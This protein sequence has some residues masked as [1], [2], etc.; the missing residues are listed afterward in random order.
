MSDDKEFL[1]AVAK[2]GRDFIEKN[3]QL[4]DWIESARAGARDPKEVVKEVWRV[5]AQNKTF[6]DGV[7]R[8]LFEAFQVDSESTDLA[9][10]P[11]REKL[12]TRWGFSEEDLIFQPFPDRPDYHMLHPLLMGM[13]VEL[14][15]FDGDVPELRTGELPE[16]G[17]P[18]V[19]VKTTARDPIV[20]G[21]ML[22]QASNE[23]LLELGAAREERQQKLEKM[24]GAM[25]EDGSGTTALIR[26]ET[27]RGVAV[28]GYRPGHKAAIRE[29]EAPS[30]IEVARMPLAE[31]QELAHKA[32]TSTQ[33]RRSAV[34][35]I[36]GLVLERLQGAGFSSLRMGG[37]KE[38]EYA[39]VVS[40]TEWVISID[41][42]QAERNPK[43]NF[44]DTAAGALT[45]KLQRGL[46][47]RASRY[48]RLHLVVAPVN[49][50]SER[51]VGWRATV[52]S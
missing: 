45:V 29:V 42:G 31:R 17:S 44:I 47:G 49:E 25:P 26:Q 52:Y 24:I 2:F 21:A 14:L 34:P 32:L 50:I 15:Q 40:E 8:A 9:H 43:F 12:L 20:V 41:G 19:P 5:A 22:R 28:A 27:E 33:G 36:A 7:E 48:T 46:A 10:F 38:A 39:Y 16:G 51:R 35:I 37:V 6:K 30:A 18:A 1:D 4:E 11:E 13:I 23:V 3:P